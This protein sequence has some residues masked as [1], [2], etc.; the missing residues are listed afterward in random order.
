MTLSRLP[1][2]T[3]DID[4]LIGDYDNPIFKLQAA[5]RT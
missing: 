1:N 4:K 2:G 3:R 5:E